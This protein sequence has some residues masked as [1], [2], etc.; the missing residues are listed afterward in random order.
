MSKARILELLAANSDDIARRFRVKHLSLFGSA[1][2]DELRPDS[3]VDVLVEFDGPATFDRY[4][5]LIRYLEVLLQRKVDVV[6]ETGL[7]PRARQQ[8][9][10]DR[11]RVA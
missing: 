4:I 5:G 11:I 1:A 10:R 8:V 7:K 2:R 9:E 3:D 6:T